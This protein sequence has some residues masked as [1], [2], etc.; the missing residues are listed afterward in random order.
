MKIT[1]T[2]INRGFILGVA[3]LSGICFVP[4]AS[5]ESYLIDLKASDATRLGS[6]GEDDTVATALNDAGQVVGIP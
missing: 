5:A 1:R 3:L 6:L 2:S 4:P